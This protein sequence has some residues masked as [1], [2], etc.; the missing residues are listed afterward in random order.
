[1]DDDTGK[2]LNWYLVDQDDF[3]RFLMILTL[4][5]KNGG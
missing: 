4:M 2:A 3:A 1:M 5:I